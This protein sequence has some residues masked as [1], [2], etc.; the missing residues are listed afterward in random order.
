MLDVFVDF[1][2]VVYVFG[3]TGGA[4]LLLGYGSNDLLQFIEFLLERLNIILVDLYF[5][6]F[7][8]S[9]GSFL[10]P[11]LIELPSQHL[12]QFCSPLSIDFLLLN[13]FAIENDIVDQYSKVIS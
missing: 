8:E 9:L 3:L 5:E 6:L 13:H 2:L 12:P 7:R 4:V 10:E 11:Q 1:S